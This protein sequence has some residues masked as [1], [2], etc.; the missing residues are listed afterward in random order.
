[1]AEPRTCASCG[2]QFAPTTDAEQ[3]LCDECRIAHLPEE[4]V[5][6]SWRILAVIGLATIVIIAITAFICG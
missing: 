2:T 3:L 6:P 4:V 5:Q 1:M